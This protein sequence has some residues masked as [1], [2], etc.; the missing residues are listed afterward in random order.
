MLLFNTLI[1]VSKITT[2]HG[3]ILM[4]HGKKDNLLL[5]IPIATKCNMV[6]ADGARLP[7]Y[8]KKLAHG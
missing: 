2:E 3:E 4:P 6:P 1:R 8:A 7:F 5:C